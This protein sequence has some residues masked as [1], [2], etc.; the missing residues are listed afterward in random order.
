MKRPP[1]YPSVDLPSM[2]AFL[3]RSIE[4]FPDNTALMGLERNGEVS[5]TSSV[6]LYQ[7]IR[8]MGT[9]LIAR[10][11]G[12]S[13]IAL[14]GENSYS[15]VMAYFSIV[16]TG[17]TVVPLDKELTVEE[18]ADQIQR[19]RVAAIC[20]T[21]QYAEE[22][23]SAVDMSDCDCLRIALGKAAGDVS[24]KDLIDSGRKEI[25]AGNDLFSDVEIDGQQTCSI[26]FTSG[27]T[28]TSKGVML[29]HENIT[30]NI[31]AA[32]ELVL[33]HQEDVML[34]ILPLHH[35]FEDLCGLF[36][37]FYYGASVALCPGVKYL[38]KYLETFSPT[39]MVLVPLY[40][41]TFH[42]KIFHAA[43]EAGSLNQLKAA[44]KISCFLQRL[45][46]NVSSKLLKRP[47]A[48][49]GGSLRIII[50]GGAP[51]DPRYVRDY[52]GLGINILHG[53][54]TTECSPIVSANRDISN[55][56]GSSGWI[57]SCC[58]VKTDAAGQLMIRGKYS[59]IMM[60][61]G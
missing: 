42:S 38:P 48:A 46:V 39:V 45:G 5:R 19:A 55:K 32:G 51:L 53:Y 49:L 9:S 37:A 25:E 47:R 12:S 40:I 34:S 17:A 22:A 26:L 21:D 2:R 29:S 59:S 43:E 18:L 36:G 24:A 1:L 23:Q 58:E 33:F 8:S 10:R 16:C 14:I 28:G 54:G 20:Y 41:E 60:P 44:L 3:E 31:N 57:C 7:D 30:S 35:C 52:R 50:S 61:G 6:E 15:W 27:T 13:R 56:D 4:L 11:L